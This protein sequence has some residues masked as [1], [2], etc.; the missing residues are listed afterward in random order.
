MN[1]VCGSTDCRELQQHYRLCM[2]CS[3]QSLTHADVLVYSATKHQQLQL[4]SLRESRRQALLHSRRRDQCALSEAKFQWPAPPP[5]A[6]VTSSVTSSPSPTRHSPRQKHLVNIVS[7][8]DNDFVSG[9]E[10][11]HQWHTTPQHATAASSSETLATAARSSGSCTARPA[12]AA[13]ATAPRWS[14]SSSCNN[15][16]GQLDDRCELQPLEHVTWHTDVARPRTSGNPLASRLRTVERTSYS[17]TAVSDSVSTFVP[18][19][20]PTVAL[21]ALSAR[22][23]RDVSA[24]AEEL[25]RLQLHEQQP[26]ADMLLLN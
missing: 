9:S 13:A 24:W 19:V 21:T 6:A 20:V 8:S 26:T 25:N 4:A 5:A 22:V 17:S 2:H 11:V 15:G 16:N 18:T 3:A 14:S 7:G 1:T 10:Y 23:A 12:S